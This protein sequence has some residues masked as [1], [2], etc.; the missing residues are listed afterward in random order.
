[1]ASKIPG[2]TKR[3]TQGHCARRGSQSDD[4][5]S[6]A[7]LPLALH[8]SVSPAQTAPPSK[9]L[10]LHVNSVATRV[11]GVGRGMVAKCPSFA[12][13]RQSSVKCCVQMPL[14]GSPGIEPRTPIA[15]IWTRLPCFGSSPIPSK[16]TPFTPTSLDHLPNKQPSPKSMCQAL[17]SEN[18]HEDS[19][20]LCPVLGS[21]VWMA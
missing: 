1:M 19:T 10:E 21:N 2:D 14:R 3:V 13:F 18:P 20:S 5:S 17:P 11:T 16:T 8:I 4:E 6:F 7:P 15:A 9:S 12:S